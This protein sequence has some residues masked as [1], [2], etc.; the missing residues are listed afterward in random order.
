MEIIQGWEIFLKI[1]DSV[2]LVI[3]FVDFIL[4]L[5]WYYDDKR[6]IHSK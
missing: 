3:I 4:I 1:P 6:R 5:F 2:C